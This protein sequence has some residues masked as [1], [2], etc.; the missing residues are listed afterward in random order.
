MRPGVGI[1]GLPR[2]L[3]LAVS[4][5]TVNRGL[6]GTGTT[7]PCSGGVAATTNGGRSF[8]VVLRT[9]GPV[10][11]IT[12]A[13]QRDAWIF[14]GACKSA[15]GPLA[16]VRNILL[17]TVDGG[18]SWHVLPP[19]EAFDPSFATATRGFA[20]RAALPPF[21]G[22]TA[23]SLGVPSAQGLL[24]TSDGGRNWRPVTGPAGCRG[25]QGE[26]VNSPSL[27]QTWV[28]CTGEPGAGA[29]SKA[30]FLSPDGGHTWRD[31]VNV[32]LPPDQPDRGISSGGYPL[33]LNFSRAGFGLLWED[34][35]VL[36]I[37]RDDG[38]SWQPTHV[39]F[40]DIDYGVS[41]AALS[42]SDAFLLRFGR[43]TRTNGPAEIDLLH[44]LDAGH[45]WSVTHRWAVPER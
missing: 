41:G 28:L 45:S 17:R 3:P 39:L 36:Y 4:F 24:T 14:V 2:Q 15:R 31:L 7:Q 13:G 18:R 21:T 34:R 37:T 8:R 26:T 9:R 6:V 10:E 27:T 35:G 30:I 33:G 23:S 44:T 32:G 38:R 29:Q 1:A 11:S 40:P 20:L 25:N 22:S 12:T 19:S 5:W 16:G 43:H 42:R